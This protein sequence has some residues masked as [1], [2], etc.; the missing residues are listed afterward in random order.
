MHGYMYS[1]VLT[2]VHVRNLKSL[3]ISG[4]HHNRLFCEWHGAIIWAENVA[5]YLD[6]ILLQLLYFTLAWT[7]L[8][9]LPRG[10]AH[11]LPKV[12]ILFEKYDI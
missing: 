8:T 7:Y 11:D 9:T 12:G 6:K 3:R 2:E 10:V 5:F 4:I 1:E